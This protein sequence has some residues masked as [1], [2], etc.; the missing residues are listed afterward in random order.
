MATI[1]DQ[2]LR[3]ADDYAAALDTLADRATANT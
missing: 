3:L 1:G 2:Q